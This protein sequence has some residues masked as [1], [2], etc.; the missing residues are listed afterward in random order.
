MRERVERYSPADLD[1]SAGPALDREARA[2]LQALGYAS[3]E[4]LWRRGRDRIPRISVATAARLS[5]VLSGELQGA[6]LEKA[7][8]EILA[9]DPKNPQANLRL[10]YVLLEA[11][12][13][14]QAVPYLK[15]AI[16]GHVPTADAH[17]GLGLCQVRERR[18][19]DAIVSLTEANRI[20]PENPVVSANLGIVYMDLGRTREAIGALTQATDL[21]PD[22]HEARFNLVRAYA[23]AGDRQAAATHARELLKRLPSNAPQR[24]EVE[25][26]LTALQ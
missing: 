12:R 10:G 2:R 24:A 21:D 6:A 26:L 11:G 19:Q 13:C 23:R 22:F 20:E 16:A 4:R 7:L 18:L 14:D 1:A 15:T 17:L 5:E 25:R 8:R 3:G 9:A